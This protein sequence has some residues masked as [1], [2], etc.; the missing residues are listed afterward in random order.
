MVTVLDEWLN[1][2]ENHASPTPLGDKT[3]SPTVLHIAFA[4]L[5]FVKIYKNSSPTV[6][7]I[8]FVFFGRNLAN[9]RGG[10]TFMQVR[11]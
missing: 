7:H 5:I 6:L 10:L 2:M 9:F 8:G 1:S 3:A 11:P 4:F